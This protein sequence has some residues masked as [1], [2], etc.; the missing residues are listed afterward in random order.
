A[1]GGARALTCSGRIVIP[2]NIV[3]ASTHMIDRVLAA[4]RGLGRRNDGTPL[5]IAST[6]VRAV[7]PEA[8]ARNVSSS[9]KT[10]P[11]CVVRR[12]CSCA[13]LASGRL[14]VSP[15]TSPYANIKKVKPMNTYVG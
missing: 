6:P 14:P 11:T 10:P 13:V 12:S 5:L 4:L 1:S 2:P 8:K 15:L 9:V 3:T 7:Q